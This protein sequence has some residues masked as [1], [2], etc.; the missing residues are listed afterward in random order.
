MSSDE[1]LERTFL[2][3][4]AALALSD[5]LLRGV[6]PSDALAIVFAMLE[7]AEKEGGFDR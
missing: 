2:E 4:D 1:E 3:R 7:E 5:L 6:D